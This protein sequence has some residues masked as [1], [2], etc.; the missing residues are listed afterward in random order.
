[1]AHF[2][3]ILY[4]LESAAKTA[5]NFK[6]LMGIA[7]GRSFVTLATLKQQYEDVTNAYRTVQA[8]QQTK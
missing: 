7:G 1:L 2:D 8:L 6:T 5:G 4:G 3:G